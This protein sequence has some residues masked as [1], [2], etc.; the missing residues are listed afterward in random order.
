MFFKY[1]I[2]DCLSITY[3]VCRIIW[4]WTNCI[5]IRLRTSSN[6]S[7]ESSGNSYISIEMMDFNRNYTA[8]QDLHRVAIWMSVLLK[9]TVDAMPTLITLIIFIVALMDVT[10]LMSMPKQQVILILIVLILMMALEEFENSNKFCI[11]I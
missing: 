5:G 11:L 8:K 9:L 6:A 1:A 3:W 4:T 2:F 7:S 10:R